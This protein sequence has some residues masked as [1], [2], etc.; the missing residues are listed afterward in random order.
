MFAKNTLDNT[1]IS[2]ERKV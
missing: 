1:I 2:R